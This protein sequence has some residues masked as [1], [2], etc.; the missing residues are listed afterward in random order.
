MANETA[1]LLYAIDG[2]PK[3]LV[4]VQIATGESQLLGA[5]S[6][7]SWN[8]TTLLLRGETVCNAETDYDQQALTLYTYDP[9]T[10]SIGKETHASD[11]LP[12]WTAQDLCYADGRYYALM[13]DDDVRGLYSGETLETMACVASPLTWSDSILLVRA[14]DVLLCSGSLLMSSRVIADASVTLVLSQTEARDSASYTLQNGV[15][16]RSVYGQTTAEILNTRSSDVDILCIT[17]E[18]TVSLKLLKDKGYFTDLSGNEILREQVSRLYPAFAK[19]LTRDDGK[20]IGWYDLADTYLPD[21]ETD[22]LAAHGMTFPNTLLEMCQQVTA[23][24]EEGVFEEEGM[25]P[26]D[27][28]SYT[29]L[30]LLT[31]SLQ[32]YVTEQQLLGGRI[33]FDSAELQE[34]LT[35]IL[36]HVPDDEEAFSQDEESYALYMMD[37]SMPITADCHLPLKVGASSPSAIPA[38]VYVLVVN[39]YSQHQEEAIRY[40][41]YCVQHMDATMQYTL[42][43]DMTDPLPNAGPV[44]EIE[45]MTEEIAALAAQEQTEAVKEALAEL[46]QRQ[47]EAEKSRYIIDA[48]DIAAWRQMAQNIIVPEENEWSDDLQRLT[49]RLAAGSLTVEGFVREGNR[50]FEMLE[51]ERGV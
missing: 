11:T 1:Y 6:T 29:R 3:Q 31:M 24:T 19:A 34:L 28:P 38:T 27:V 17:P 30:N 13:S 44:R 45:Q 14:D 20:I 16:F 26:L 7:D 15:T 42:F 36:T 50:Y 41:A 4:R 35:Y 22:L 51:Q 46:R 2:K 40:L 43:A 8:M 32:R 21:A 18:D 10:G 37:V 5:F 33:R 23:L 49:E 48:A 39:P 25:V 47:A 9:Q 12:L